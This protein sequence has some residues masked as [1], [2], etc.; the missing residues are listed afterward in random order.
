MSFEHLMYVLFKSYFQRV[1][2]YS[3][4]ETSPAKFLY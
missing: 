1:A 2:Y 3:I 4:E